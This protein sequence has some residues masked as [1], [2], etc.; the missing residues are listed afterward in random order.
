MPLCTKGCYQES[1]KI[2]YGMGENIC[3]LYVQWG[4]TIRVYKEF[5]HSTIQRQLNLKMDRRH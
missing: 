1:E 3:K 4:S 5:I 2:T